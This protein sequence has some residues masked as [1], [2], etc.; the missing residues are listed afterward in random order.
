LISADHTFDEVPLLS[1]ARPKPCE[2]QQCYLKTSTAK[3]SSNDRLSSGKSRSFTRS[4][5]RPAR[6][7]PSTFLF[8][9]IHLS[10]SPEPDGSVENHSLGIARNKPGPADAHTSVMAKAHGRMIHRINSE[11]LRGRAIAPR[12]RYV[13]EPLYSRGPYGLSTVLDS[14]NHVLWRAPRP[15]GFVG[16]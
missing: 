16:L 1:S 5:K 13:Q 6:T 9:Q 10:N 8:L 3:V 11:G 2:F 4:R 12:R 15:A 14:R 7:P